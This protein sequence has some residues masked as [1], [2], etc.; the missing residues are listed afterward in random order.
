M[1]IVNRVLGDKSDDNDGA[2][3]FVLSGCGVA[4]CIVAMVWIN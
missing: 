4:A 3:A 2:L 1:N